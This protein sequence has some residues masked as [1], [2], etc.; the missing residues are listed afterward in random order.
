M[1]VTIV[2]GL[3]GAGKT[4]IAHALAAHAERGVH[5]DT[6]DV[7]ERF[8][9]RGRVLPGQE[10]HDEAERQL[11]LRRRNLCALANNFAAEGFEVAISD[12]VLWPGLWQQY[13]DR[14]DVMPRLVLLDPDPEAIAAR[15]A[16]RHKQVAQAWAHLRA[17][18]DAWTSV[19][20]LR[21]DTTHLD[22]PQTLAAIAAAQRA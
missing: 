20:G 19:P 6:D 10:P 2:S 18:L 5:L 9:V 17:D 1:S 7:G 21:L 3:P 16:G 15:D 13:L 4:T 22:V 12:V 11:D 14:L 8:V